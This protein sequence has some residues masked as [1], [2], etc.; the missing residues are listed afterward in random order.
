MLY[1]IELFK[2]IKPQF[3]AWLWYF[4]NNVSYEHLYR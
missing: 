2:T 3:V 4:M 1:Y